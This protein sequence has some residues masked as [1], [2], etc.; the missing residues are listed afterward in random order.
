MSTRQRT[1][2]EPFRR[3]LRELA[4]AHDHRP[5]TLEPLDNGTHRTAPLPVTGPDLEPVTNEA[6]DREAGQ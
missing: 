4:G 2:L 5:V 3:R 1:S 6:M